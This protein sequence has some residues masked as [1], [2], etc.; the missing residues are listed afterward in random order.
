VVVFSVPDEGLLANVVGGSGAGCKAMPKIEC[1]SRRVLRV[2]F[3]PPMWWHFLE[4]CQLRCGAKENTREKEK[5]EAASATEFSEEESQT[6]E[7][8]KSR[9]HA[10]KIN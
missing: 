3:I 8:E 5:Q 6:E 9:R 10:R 4:G 1:D 2:V 7:K